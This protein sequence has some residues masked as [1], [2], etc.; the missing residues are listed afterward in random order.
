LIPKHRKTNFNVVCKI[1]FSISWKK[2]SF[3][4]VDSARQG[5]FFRKVCFRMKIDIG[6]GPFNA[7]K[8]RY[9]DFRLRK[10]WLTK[11]SKV[12][13]HVH[14]DYRSRKNGV[15]LRPRRVAGAWVTRYYNIV[16]SSLE[17]SRPTER[18]L[19]AR[20]RVRTPPRCFNRRF[21]FRYF[22]GILLCY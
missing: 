6:T 16:S 21:C 4:Y 5:K 11:K 8:I 7:I 1:L 9:Y 13:M 15:V 20:R 2:I 17:T 3:N 10:I 19:Q 22:F 14:F 18:D 12:R